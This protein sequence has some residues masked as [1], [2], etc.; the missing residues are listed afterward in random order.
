[1][2]GERI[3]PT[4]AT[5][6]TSRGPAQECN[7]TN[8]LK[9]TRKTFARAKDAG[10]DRFLRLTLGRW[11]STH[12]AGTPPRFNKHPNKI[13]IGGRGSTRAEYIDDLEGRVLLE[14][15]LIRAR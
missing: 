2:D 5:V 11:N 4:A 10:T 13:E 9:L 3:S 1:M 15:E 7:I 6:H 14:A 12:T 8:A